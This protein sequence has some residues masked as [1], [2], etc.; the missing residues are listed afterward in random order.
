VFRT[1]ARNG[2]LA[3]FLAGEFLSSIGDWLYLVALL[4]FVNQVALQLNEQVVATE[5]VQETLGNPSA[6]NEASWLRQSARSRP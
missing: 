1:I 3:R 4:V 6:P 5:N 2:A